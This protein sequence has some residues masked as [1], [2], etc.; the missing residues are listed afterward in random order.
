MKNYPKMKETSIPWLGK[1]PEHWEV[2]RLRFIF[3]MFTG[4][5]VTKEELKEAGIP[6][7]GYGLIHS[8]YTFDLDVQRDPL[9]CVDEAFEFAKPLAVLK[10]NDFVFCDTSEDVE[11]SGNCV[12]IFRLAGTKMIAGS[13]TVRLTPV[14][15][16]NARY[17]AYLFK[18]TGWKA[19]VQCHVTGTKVYSIS[20]SILKDTFSIL[21]PLPEQ[22]A[23]AAYLDK[24][25]AKIDAL[26]A[27]QE[28]L[29]TL[30]AEK[31]KA[32]ISHV[33]TRGLDPK[34]K[35][36]PSGISWLGDIPE[37]WEVKRLKYTIKGRLKYGANESSEIDD[38]CL[39]RYVR[40]TDIDDKGKLKQE[41]FRSLPM[42]IAKDYLLEDGDVLFARSGATSGKT[43]LYRLEWGT[44]AYAGYLIRA[45]LEK[46]RIDPQ[47]LRH[48]TDSGAYWQWLAS[49]LI[50]ATI[51][52]VSAEKYAD[53]A[54][55][56]PTI[57]EQRTIAAYLDKATAKL[58]ALAAKAEEGIALLKERRSALISEVVTGKVRVS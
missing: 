54:L 46:T 3:K 36:K 28:K 7:I 6:C 13:H 22:Q 52:N 11:G 47:F 10:E 17:L 35:L 18:A 44:C 56:M 33:V 9:P 21:P 19:Q 38:P 20:Q 53:L 14:E 29:C 34:A 8:K 30:L 37:H 55:P 51:Q 48:F 58:D 32:L 42:E 41:T 1:I 12:Q 50:Q 16:M 40:I 24:A 57:E 49:S 2:K 26:I 4:I 5:S 31:R 45:R 27:E 43:S 15:K 23:I 25:T 39:P